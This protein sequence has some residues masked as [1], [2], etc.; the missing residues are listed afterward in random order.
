MRK[1]IIPCLIFLLL[2]FSGNISANRDRIE[3]EKKY[4]IIVEEIDSSAFYSAKENSMYKNDTIEAVSDFKIA[5]EMLKGVVEFANDDNYGDF[6]PVKKIYFRNGSVLDLEKEY[7]GYYFIAYFPSEDIL[8]CESG[9]M[10]DLSLNLTNG[11][12]TEEAGNPSIILHSPE[13]RFRLNGYFCYFNDCCFYFIQEKIAGEYVK[14]IDIDEE[15]KRRTK[16]YPCVIEESFWLDENTIY[17]NETEGV[18]GYSK[19]TIVEM[20]AFTQDTIVTMTATDNLVWIYVEWMGTGMITAN[21]VALENSYEREIVRESRKDYYLRNEIYTVNDSV[22]LVATGGAQLTYLE[23]YNSLTTLDV[24]NCPELKVLDCSNNSLSELDVTKCTKLTTLYCGDNRLLSYLDV[25]KC[26]ELTTLDCSRNALVAL[27]ITNCPKLENLSAD[28][29]NPIPPVATFDGVKLS[30]RN[31]ITFNGTGVSI[32][33]ISHNGISVGDSIVW[34]RERES[35]G[36]TFRFTTKLPDGIT[37]DSFSGM[38]TQRW[39]KTSGK[40]ITGEQVVT[41]TTTDD[42]VKISAGWIGAGSIFANGVELINADTT[43]NLI[44]PTIN[45]L[46]VITTTGDAQLTQL[47]CSKNDLTDLNIINGPELMILE[48]DYNDLSVLAAT[49]CPKLKKLNCISNGLKVLDVTQC[50]ELEILN[51]YYNPLKVL[52]VTNCTKLTELDCK[53]N[54]L[55]DLDISKCPMLT[56]LDIFYNGLTALD[57]SGFP[58]LTKLDCSLNPL[59]GLDVTKNPMLTYLHCGSNS[60]S[61]LDVTQCPMLTY[62][63]CHHNP[64]KELDVTN[65]P[66]LTELNCSDNSLSDLDVTKCMLLER[67]KCG[68]NLLGTLDLSN[69]TMLTNLHCN[70]IH[71]YELDITMCTELTELNFTDN[72]LSKLD[73]TKCPKLT[74]LYCS[75][76]RLTALDINSAELTILDCNDN[77]LKTLNVTKCTELTTLDCNDNSLKSLDVTNCTKLEDLNCGRNSLSTLDVTKCTKLTSIWCSKNS[78]TALNVTKCA[79]LTELGC[80]NNSLS[81]LNTN[82]TELKYLSAEEQTPILPVAKP[83]RNN[84][85]IRNP[86]KFAN[87]K[88]SIDNISHGGTYTN[89]NIA[90]EV[91]DES[92]EV[93]FSFATELPDNSKGKPFS[94][95][96]TQP[97]TKK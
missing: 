44:Y 67:L 34:T 92:G 93:T 63:N 13:K 42:S 8:L 64:L 59:I 85:S 82:G 43:E 54:K 70:N 1:N 62:L 28:Y 88:V 48:C 61:V 7:G 25:S 96:V 72:S 94:G 69:C 49:N 30:I 14:I 77:S 66:M 86:I 23:C 83:K 81:D 60:L 33:D 17:Y 78:L 90:W 3:E 97:W 5:K 6:Q 15:F 46:I 11:K 95:T 12:K 80:G 45:G 68:N 22:V 32:Q 47:K 52:D 35:G 76:N 16:I 55:S 79:E 36:V 51:C 50:P 37:G 29:Q 40:M 18:E 19:M 31:P 41:M 65:C 10:S 71:I 56:K 89:G 26:P 4:S 20:Q 57:L 24:T 84:L 39:T 2:F 91:L 73:V 27:D 9:H 21:G 74:K 87:N 38:A 75:Y 58:M 53:Y